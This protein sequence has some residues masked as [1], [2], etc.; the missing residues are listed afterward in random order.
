[1]KARTHPGAEKHVATSSSDRTM[2]RE[3][4]EQNDSDS[5]KE[6][7]HELKQSGLTAEDVASQSAYSDNEADVIQQATS[8][9]KNKKG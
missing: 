9:N 7:N 6:A 3:K 2:E 1:M 4:L 8:A 5:R